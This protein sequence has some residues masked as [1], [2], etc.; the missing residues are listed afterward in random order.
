MGVRRDGPKG[1]STQ[2][3]EKKYYKIGL[4]VSNW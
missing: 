1:Q 3:E 4:K 2:E